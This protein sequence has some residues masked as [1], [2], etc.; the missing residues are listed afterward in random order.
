MVKC[1]TDGGKIND[2]EHVNVQRDTKFPS[3]PALNYLFVLY[4]ILAS[5]KLNGGSSII[6]AAL[7]DI[8]ETLSG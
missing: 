4:V 6:T 5:L 2:R 8:F 7:R 3:V 1:I